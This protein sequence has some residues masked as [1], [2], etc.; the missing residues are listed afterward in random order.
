VPPDSLG[1][2]TLLDPN[3]LESHWALL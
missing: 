2:S 3:L 1:C